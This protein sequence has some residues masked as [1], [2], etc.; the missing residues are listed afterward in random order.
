MKVAI[1][2]I[3]TN[4][5]KINRP[6][7][8]TSL[9][10][11]GHRV[12]YIGQDSDDDLHPDYKRYNVRFLS[13]PLGRA[14]T[15][16]LKELKSVAETR[17]ALKENRID[18]LIV[19]GIRTFP[20]MVLAAKLAGV[21][22]ILCIVN[23]S[24]RLFQLEGIKGYFVKLISYPMLWLSFLL[25]DSVLFQNPDDINMI[26]SKG[27]LWRNNYELVHGSGV[28]LETF[29]SDSLENIMVFTM[30][31]RLTGLKGV[32]EY[33]QAARIVKQ[34]N[35]GVI[36]NLVG[37]MDDESTIDMLE[38]K[39]AI[40]DEIINLIGKVDDVRPYINECRVFVLPS[41]YPEG[42]PRTILEAMAMGRPIIT[43]DSMG[44]RETV[45]D[46]VNG[47][48]IPPRNIEALA[49]KMSW[50]IENTEKLEEMGNNSRIICEEKFDVHKVNK[51]IID[52]LEI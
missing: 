15:N 31:S 3:R 52:K 26:K 38:L 28:N 10:N 4:N 22:K 37:P 46:G 51:V 18:G 9:Q 36:F 40:D 13:I 11:L 42:V 48:L 29:Y 41:Y 20:T 32:N 30:I 5:T 24:G 27:L 16:P 35:P 6:E 47:F 21:K 33:V 1:S 25:A 19:Y 17:K 2:A 44:C 49:D 14:N 34:L 43:T 23:G 39:K 45:I 7:L 12:I 50:M 8:V